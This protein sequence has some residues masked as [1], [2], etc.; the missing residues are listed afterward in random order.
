MIEL[1]GKY[2]DA[3]IMIDDVEEGVFEQVYD[4][5]NSSTSNGL[6]VRIMPDTHQG[7]SICI[8]FSM[9][10]GVYLNPMHIGVDIGCGMASASF[11]K[12]V[13]IDLEK[14]D[15]LIRERIPMG[16]NLQERKRLKNIPFD[17]VQK[18]ADIFIKKYNDKFGT[19]Y[20]VPTY[21]EKW[22]KN[23][24]KQIKM[25]DN[26]FWNAIGTL[27]SGNHF[28]EVG[29]SDNY[30]KYWVT[31]HSG[32]RNFGLKIADYWT[33][34]ARGK[35]VVASDEYNKERDEIIM[36]TFPKNLIPSKLEELK[37]KYSLGINKE[38]LTGDNMMGY[39]FDMIFAQQYALWNRM[40]MLDIFK[41]IIEISDYDEVIHTIHNYI[42]FN[43]F[44]IRKGAIPS[45]K[46]EKM[47]IP[48]NMRDGIL[49]CEGKSNP[50]WNFSAPH[51]SGRLLSRS[52]AKVSID[53]KKFKET[54][55]GVYS[56][57]VCK[58]TLDES[59]FAYK[60][61]D[62]IEKAIEPTAVI[63]DRIKPIL[64]IKDT[65][66]SV[67]WKERKAAAKKRDKDR[68]AERKMKRG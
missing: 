60:R 6:K 56:T 13:K 11:S 66:K 36:N 53:M 65:G 10:L 61:S 19:S 21:D 44:I 18:I 30:K 7:N 9:E 51:G 64:N 15:T 2:T 68:Q 49:L 27:G 24:L 26:K 3:V 33:N 38:Y 52:K 20:V 29:R 32:S 55:K 25:D 1:K 50:D 46:G 28:V 16:F 17:E 57:S 4:I 39:L 35:V 48:F 31:I 34:V 54:M 5:I 23:K 43:D 40:T 12:D 8:G 45:Y 62:I 67:S 63:L 42:D 22:L 58:E 37:N 41:T 47:I 14:V 59:P